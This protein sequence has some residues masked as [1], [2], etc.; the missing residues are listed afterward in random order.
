LPPKGRVDS[1]ESSDGTHQWIYNLPDDSCCTGSAYD[2][3]FD[4]NWHCAE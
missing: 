3:T 1:V 2:W 4:I